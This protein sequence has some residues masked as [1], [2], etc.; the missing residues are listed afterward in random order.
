MVVKECIDFETPPSDSSL[1]K[2]E[3]FSETDTESSDDEK[4]LDD[5]MTMSLNE[6]TYVPETDNTTSA[7]I[8]ED[9]IEV[10]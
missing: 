2:L 7:N 6:I 3:Y 9:L 10:Q 5:S 4:Y 8:V 1:K